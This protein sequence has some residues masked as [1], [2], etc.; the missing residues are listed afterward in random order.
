MN[1]DFL[2]IGQ[3]TQPTRRLGQ[4]SRGWVGL[5]RLTHIECRLDWVNPLQVQVGQDGLSY[6][7]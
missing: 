1:T 7:F 5:N 6:P 3:A 2:L 4:A